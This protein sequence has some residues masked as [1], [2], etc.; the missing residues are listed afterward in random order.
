MP[1]ETCDVCSAPAA[2]KCSAC[3][4]AAY[5][6]KEHQ[7][8]DWKKHKDVCR[9]FEIRSSPELGKYLV[10]SRDL[11]P[12]DVIVS[13]APLVVGP[14]LHSEQAMCL[15]CH[16]PTRYDSDYRC[17]KCLWPCCGPSC[18]A[19]PKL[20]AAECSILRLQ[21]R[22]N[23]E[24][25][26]GK[27]VGIYHYDA[28]TPLRCLL[29]QRRNPRKWQQILEMES[30]VK[31]RGP[32]T[33]VFREIRDRVVTFLQEN[34]LQKL[35]GAGKEG[36][37]VLEDCSENTLHKICGVLDVNGLDIR[38]ALGA[39]VVAL[40]PTVYL[41]EHDCVPNTRHSFEIALGDKQYRVTVR[42]TRQIRKGEHISTMYTHALWG[43]QARRDHLMS[44]KY[45]NC[46]CKRCS[47]PTELGTYLSAMR[48]LGAEI[49]SD[50]S[51]DAD[52]ASC[53]GTQLP[54][55]PLDDNTDWRCDRCPVVLSASQVNELVSR[56]G[57]EVDSVQASLLSKNL[58][59]RIYKT[60]ILPVVLYG[61]ETWTLTLREE[62]RLRVFENK[63]LRKIFG[64]KRGEVTGEWRKLHNAELHALL[65]SP[66]IIRNIKSR[67]L[68][69]AGHVARMGESRNAYRVL[70]GRPEGKRP[71]GK[72]R[73]R[74]EDN[75]KMDLREVGNDD[76]DWINL[77]QDR[78]RW[79]A[80]VRA[81]MNL[82]SSPT[83]TQLEELLSKLGMFL[84]PHHYHLYSVKHSLV[85]L[86]G[87]QQGYQTSQLSEQQLERKAGLLPAS[88][89]KLLLVVSEMCR[90]LLA[91][92]DK[93]D[94]GSSRL[95]LYSS[96]LLHELHSAEFHL[97]RRKFERDPPSIS[98]EEM[99][100]KAQGAKSLLLTAIKVLEP[101]PDFSSGSRMMGLVRKALVDL[102][103]WP[104]TRSSHSHKIHL[105]I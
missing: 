19:D 15:G 71:L 16:V 49:L 83:V 59:V 39:E 60:V 20:H 79:R 1:Q 7:K 51:A 4:Q 66:D 46:R 93:V 67:R 99:T 78:N 37:A 81:A 9:P 65:S 53:G 102:E 70:V 10:A 55:S 103:S 5:C 80:Y 33:E 104:G 50:G 96:V 38:L 8:Q 82:R 23:L 89:T 18:P 41:M 45:F 87:H 28:V 52:G 47:D 88:V 62:H 74:W 92:T 31:K 97:A 36:D 63:V 75:I 73:C 94:P 32:G 22:R 72:P 76:R 12:G 61:R 21:T 44:T 42:A 43:T 25:A 26:A 30:H 40:Y 34:Y 3:K 13:E 2:H 105:K 69:W 77:A 98:A 91:V 58:K 17:P 90:D 95:A 14:K 29:L 35:S 85:Q 64:A 101:E 100:R 57:E 84:H 54:V 56:I 6:S 27:D 86:Y 48:C 24:A 68:R 11:S